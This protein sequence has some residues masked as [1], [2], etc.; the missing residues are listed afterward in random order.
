MKIQD[1]LYNKAKDISNF[2]RMLSYTLDKAETYRLINRR[3]KALQIIN[4]IDGCIELDSNQIA[5]LNRYRTVIYAEYLIDNGF[6]KSEDKL[7]FIQNNE[8]NYFKNS[9]LILNNT[10]DSLKSSLIVVGDTFKLQSFNFANKYKWDFGDCSSTTDSLTIHLYSYPGIYNINLKEDFNCKTTNSY[11]KVIVVPKPKSIFSIIYPETKS[12]VFYF[13]NNTPK[14]YLSE[15]KCQTD[16]NSYCKLDSTKIRYSYKWKFGNNSDTLITNLPDTIKYSFSKSGKYA[17][18]LSNYIEIYDTTSKTWY[19]SGIYKSSYDTINF[20]VP[21]IARFN[22]IQYNC[23]GDTLFLNDQSIGNDPFSYFWDFGD[24][25]TSSQQNVKIKYN[26][27]GNY[28]VMLIIKD[29]LSQIDTTIQNISVNQLPVINLSGDSSVCLG[30]STT[31]NVSGASRYKWNFL[32]TITS[33]QNITVNPTTT[34]TYIV[35][36]EN[37]NGCTAS[38]SFITNVKPLEINITHDTII[39]QG[40]AIELIPSGGN[41]YIWNTYDTTSTIIISPENTITYTVTGFDRNGCYGSTQEI[42]VINKVDFGSNNKIKTCGN[43][44]ITLQDNDPYPGKKYLWSTGDTTSNIIVSPLNDQVY[45]LTATN[46]G[47]SVSDSIKV[48]ITPGIS[49]S[50]SDITIC[51]GDSVLITSNASNENNANIFFWSNGN[52]KDSIEVRPEFTTS[53]TVTINNLDNGCSASNNITVNVIDPAPAI[54]NDTTI[55]PGSSVLLSVFPNENEDYSFI[56]SD[57]TNNSSINVYPQQTTTYT[58]TSSVN[59]TCSAVVQTIIYVN[60]VN[61][62]IFIDGVDQ[63]NY[64][65]ITLCGSTLSFNLRDKNSNIYNSYLWSTGDVL[66]SIIINPTSNTTYSVTSTKNGCITTDSII[67]NVFPAPALLSAGS[68]EYVCTN[69]N[70]VNFIANSNPQNNQSYSWSTGSLSQSIQDNPFTTTTYTVTATETSGCFSTAQVIAIVNGA[71]IEAIINNNSL[72]PNNLVNICGKNNTV[73]LQNKNY[74]AGN[75]YIW[76]TG[77]TS[78]SIVLQP[79]YLQS[80]SVT[81]T[82]NGC[83]SSD[84]IFLNSLPMSDLNLPGDISVCPNSTD[85]ISICA[86]VNFNDNQIFNWSGSDGSN[87]N[88]TQCIYVNPT[89]GTNYTVTMTEPNGCSASKSI[90][91]N[92]SNIMTPFISSDQTICPNKYTNISAWVNGSNCTYSWNNGFSSS[93]INV[94]PN[95]TTTYI[96][97]VN[98][99]PTCSGTAQTIVTVSDKLIPQITPVQTICKGQ[100]V[101]LS[102]SSY[103]LTY[104]YNYTWSTEP[105]DNSTSQNNYYWLNVSPTQT[106]TYHLSVSGSPS[107]SGT[108]QTVVVINS[109]DLGPDKNI[110][111]CGANTMII[112]DKNFK[113]GNTYLWNTGENASSI[114]LNELTD[115]STPQ[116]YTVTL[117][118]ENGCTSSDGVTVNVTSPGATVSAGPDRTICNSNNS[119]TLN[120]VVDQQNNQLYQWNSGETNSSININPLLTTTYV[121]TVSE[122]TGC[123]ES[124]QVVVTVVGVQLQAILD[125]EIQWWNKNINYCSNKSL[126]LKDMNYN[127]GNSYQWNTGETTSSIS[128]PDDITGNKFYQVTVTGNGCTSTDGIWINQLKSTKV[129]TMH[130]TILI[131]PDNSSSILLSAYQNEFNN[132]S[133]MW[134]TGETTQN[135]QVIPTQSA[136]YT[137]TMSDPN[138]CTSTDHILIKVSDHLKPFINGNQTICPTTSVSLNS[139]IPVLTNVVYSWSDGSLSQSIDV[140]P[141]TTSTYTVTASNSPTCS[142]TAQAV[143]NLSEQ[144]TPTISPDQSICRGNSILLYASN[145]NGG[146]YTWSNGGGGSVINV[147]PSET[148]T[149]TV[150]VNRTPTCSGTAQVVVTVKGV[151]LSFNNNIYEL[152]NGSSLILQD[153]NSHIGDKYLWNTGDT[154]SSIIVSPS[155]NQIYRVTST[156]NGCTST[157]EVAVN[158]KQFKTVSLDPDFTV[159]PDNTIP[160][161]INANVSWSDYNQYYSQPYF[162]W[163]TGENTQSINVLPSQTT[164]Y[165]VTMYDN[166]CTASD[167][168][169]VNTSYSLQVNKSPDMIL[170]SGSAGY[171]DVNA[172]KNIGYNYRWNTGD[173]TNYMHVTPSQSTIYT[174]TV[175]NSPSCSGTAQVMITVVDHY[176]PEIETYKDTIC[177]GDAINLSLKDGYKYKE[178]TYIW[179]NTPWSNCSWCSNI[180]LSP[181]QTATYKLRIS[182]GTCFGDVQK[183]ITVFGAYLGNKNIINSCGADSLQLIDYNNQYNSISGET[184][185]WST[186]DTTPNIKFKTNY[187]HNY[188]LTVSGNGCTTSDTVYV[189]ITPIGTNVTLQQLATEV[190]I[191]TPVE[192]TANLSYWNNP[193][194]TWFGK[195]YNDD[196]YSGQSGSQQ[197][198]TVTPASNSKYYVLVTDNNG[199]TSKSSEITVKVKGAFLGDSQ[200]IQL[201]GTGSATIT[202]LYA[203]TGETYSWNTGETTSSII[204]TPP[205]SPYYNYYYLTVTGN[206]C[207]STAYSAVWVRYIDLGQDKAICSNNKDSINIC[208]NSFDIYY[209]DSYNTHWNTGNTEKCIN[210]YPTETSTYTV[211]VNAYNGCTLTDDIIINV[212]ASE[213]SAGEDQTIECGAYAIITA[214]GTD[215]YLWNTGQITNTINVHPTVTTTYIVTG[216]NENGCYSTSQVVVKVIPLQLSAGEDKTICMGSSIKLNSTAGLFYHWDNGSNSQ[217]ITVSPSINT[218]YSITGTNENGCSSKSSVSVTVNTIPLVSAGSDQ[219]LCFG[220]KTMLK[221]TGAGNYLWS[222]N[223]TSDSIV[224]FP[225]Q[226]TTYTVTGTENGCSSTDQVIVS[227]TNDISFDH[228]DDFTICKGTNVKFTPKGNAEFYYFTGTLFSDQAQIT[229]FTDLGYL[230]GENLNGND[231]NKAVLESGNTWVDQGVFEYSYPDNTT[232]IEF[233]ITAKDLLNY[234]C[235]YKQHVKVNINSENFNPPSTQV[236][237]LGN[238]IDLSATGGNGSYTWDNKIISQPY[239]VNPQKTTIYNV[240]SGSCNANVVVIVKDPV[241]IINPE[242]AT[243]INGGIVT[244]EGTL[245]TKDNTNL[246]PDNLNAFGYYWHSDPFD[247]KVNQNI[248]QNLLT[249]MPSVT[250]T[251]TL[252]IQDN[253]GC[254]ATNKTIVYVNNNCSG[255]VSAMISGYNPSYHGEPDIVYNITVS[256]ING[257]NQNAKGKLSIDFDPKLYFTQFFQI[258]NNQLNYCDYNMNSMSHIDLDYDI[259]PNSSAIY[260]LK[261]NNG[262]WGQHNTRQNDILITTVTAS[263]TDSNTI[264]CIND[265]NICVAKQT[266]DIPWDPNF[267]IVNPSGDCNSHYVSKSDTLY[268]TI[269]FENEGNYWA[270]N[271]AIRDSLDINLDL[272]SFEIVKSDH[273]ITNYTINNNLLTISFDSIM[274]PWTSLDKEHCTGYV[275]YKIKAKENTISGTKINNNANIYFDYNDPIITNKVFNTIVDNF[276]YPTVNAGA[277]VTIAKGN[278]TRLSANGGQK[279]FWS[280]GETSSVITVSPSVTT[281]YYVFIDND[282]CTASDMVV[283]SVIDC[284]SIASGISFSRDKTICAGESIN[285]TASGGEYYIWEMGNEQYS[286]KQSIEVRP[287]IS[288]NYIVTVKKQNVCKYIDTIRVYVNP[289]PLLSTGS[290]L[291]ICTGQVAKITAF[292]ANT[293]IWNNGF[294]GASLC[295]TPLETTSYTVTGTDLN[296]CSASNSVIVTVN[297]LPFVSTG[298]DL[299]ICNG[300]STMLSAYGANTYTWNSGKCTDAACNLSVVSPTTTTTY[301]VTGSDLNG[302]TASEDVIVNVITVSLNLGSDKTICNGSSNSLTLSGGKTYSWSNGS[303]EGYLNVTNINGDTAIIVYPKQTTSYIVTGYKKGCSA[304]DGILITV[305]REKPNAGLPEKVD[306]CLGSSTTLTASGGVYYTWNDDKGISGTSSTTHSIT[307]SPTHTTVYKVTITDQNGC[308]GEDQVQVEVHKVNANAGVDKVICKG[309]TV[310]LKATGGSS[311]R[312]TIYDGQFITDQT[313]IVNPTV[314]STYYLTAWDVEGCTGT[315]QSIVT[316]INC[317]NKSKSN[318]SDLD[319]ESSDIAVSVYPNPNSGLF[320]VKISL[321]KKSD[322]DV[323]MYNTFGIK[324]Y[325]NILLNKEKTFQFDVNIKNVSPGLYLLV[326]ELNNDIKTIEVMKQ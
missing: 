99:G 311:Y 169:V 18:S 167:S 178:I 56:W 283:V 276:V 14:F 310:K 227:V 226:S 242:N 219:I 94:A 318:D 199:C 75:T 27:T 302:C 64:K 25:T 109:V 307:V 148:T 88:Q 131:C 137:V 272:N 35:I 218:T 253:N 217:F 183:Q 146:Y 309:E 247:G 92:V 324:V 12:N 266:V 314:T 224:V 93:N 10:I 149:Y 135:I 66:P 275:I 97:T 319:L 31:L 61:I 80:Y 13:I 254:T 182:N 117:T 190:C 212:D 239:T 157:D 128:I 62:G 166:G 17:I 45:K 151:L 273:K 156:S 124:A 95:F 81:V 147:S 40:N 225:T 174:V 34:S 261:L 200:F 133:F 299:T 315:D 72:F 49:L 111:S 162:Y 130:D 47:C 236:I 115:P 274:L 197:Q 206:G 204:V 288:S 2:S 59:Q 154:S 203:E 30:N 286:T 285:L 232:S 251:Y 153:Y 101:F 229:S 6:L 41:R 100:Q 114:T 258:L 271:I 250:T 116:F 325:E 63:G 245:Y 8:N 42:V 68:N 139:W 320:T 208:I 103:E 78:H 175:S 76:S 321:S 249:V 194:F 91:V 296:G 260:Q 11:K 26:Q 85:Y 268:Y 51:K 37:D 193:T 237:C 184:Y 304:T 223:E 21:A 228:I 65:N 107:C 241:A 326:I 98:D 297:P 188:I 262:S 195:S 279:F 215:H 177:V 179:D 209:F 293:Y 43:S 160:T 143:I 313:V 36:G 23:L 142:G 82:V 281:T 256:N 280:T 235:S 138:G 210:V 19:N 221:A 67:V 119:I 216:S 243:I 270:T 155:T 163:N 233:D 126:I 70:L 102:I 267:K 89:L 7:K 312:W 246:I 180:N 252:T 29:S 192:L 159:C 191:N 145:S 5:Y 322:V 211:S 186:G 141:S 264:D 222:N 136:T 54:N 171:I 113:S 306:I 152:C 108:A 9:N 39:C 291:P 300:S 15:T 105:Y 20:K 165:T 305:I 86:G 38:S 176:Q 46:N 16:T 32:D 316:V 3:D 52:V 205:V 317:N 129:I 248:N 90:T 69:N 172:G 173:T 269:E 118:D 106:T 238:S 202:D 28:S 121:V 181:S 301:T 84:E 214:N 231:Y 323:S 289:L 83:T 122:P 230:N 196:Y 127:D 161:T 4:N 187:S 168:I 257:L 278:T 57:G 1:T 74:Q 22:K 60:N 134:N 295:I 303:D 220:S 207:T 125:G 298:S 144:I 44:T 158:V 112:K 259:D 255:D 71:K 294:A 110:P 263:T 150:T 201:C 79:P 290:D 284:D 24:G 140:T 282:G 240:Q 55:C 87:Y 234:N 50:S 244:I 189:N 198:I 77:D 287:S 96:V 170:C 308:T 265:N 164:T 58:V 132:Q 213:V 48:I 33:S 277:D 120:A 185:L 292:G 73:V 104:G 123:T 53:Y